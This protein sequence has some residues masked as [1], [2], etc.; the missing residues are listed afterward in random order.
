MNLFRGDNNRG[1]DRPNKPS[2]SLGDGLKGIWRK[3]VSSSDKVVPLAEVEQAIDQGLRHDPLGYSSVEG[4]Y[5]SLRNNVEKV[6]KGFCEQRGQELLVKSGISRET[7]II[8]NTGNRTLN[9]TI[10]E[11]K[12]TIHYI[13]RTKRM[14]DFAYSVF[15]HDIKRFES[16]AAPFLTEMGRIFERH[17]GRH[18]MITPQYQGELSG[19]QAQP[20][21][22]QG[23]LSGN[24]A[25]GQ[26]SEQTLPGGTQQTNEG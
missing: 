19:N 25:G 24:Q 14:N 8:P 12:A 3:M 15:T 23:E 1:S 21:E 5:K 9:Q 11:L 13:R 6:I 4:R 7:H 16:I 22:Y 18:P 10:G 26:I 2:N 17:Y 20:P